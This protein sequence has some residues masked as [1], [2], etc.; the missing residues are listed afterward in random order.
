MQTDA[1][2]WAF[3]KLDPDSLRNVKVIS[4]SLKSGN[5]SLRGEYTYNGGSPG[6]VVVQYTGNKFSCLQFWDAVIGCREIRSAAQG[7]AMRQLVLTGGS[8]GGHSSGS[9]SD[10][11]DDAQRGWADRENGR[12][13]A[14][15][16]AER[17]RAD[18]A[19]RAAADSAYRSLQ[20]PY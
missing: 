19:S 15:A 16:D 11:L 10:G 2:G 3:N 17:A 4:G 12:I 20:N 1:R 14:A 8:G 6:W 5:F 18:A 7:A 9:A 13:N